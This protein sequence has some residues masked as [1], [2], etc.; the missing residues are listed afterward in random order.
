LRR[1]L[2]SIDLRI[3][4]V[5]QKNGRIT[6]VDLAAEV[7]LSPSPCWERMRRLERAGFITAYRA[8]VDLHR[9]VRHESFFVEVTLSGHSA[10]DFQ[11]FES[12][13]LKVP[14]IVECHATGGGVDY[15]LRVV[16]VDVER[17]QGLIDGLLEADVGIG[18][19]FTYIVTKAVK[20]FRGYPF[21]IIAGIAGP[22]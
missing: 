10:T 15:L 2:D 18:R 20:P 5:L 19:Y 17:Y 1:P 9:V 21:E 7:G 16:C 22:D 11:R 8:E 3:L 14:E 6:K 12:A 4:A 13:I